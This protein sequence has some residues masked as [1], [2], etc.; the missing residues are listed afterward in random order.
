MHEM[1]CRRGRPHERVTELSKFGRG[2]RSGIRLPPRLAV[3]EGEASQR[4][5]RGDPK[6]SV[7][8]D[9][10]AID[11]RQWWESEG[12]GPAEDT[13]VGVESTDGVTIDKQEQRVVNELNLG[14]HSGV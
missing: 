9:G 10:L 1:G 13:G 6:T 4:I 3:A 2:G 14:W 8:S 7:T 12:G 5:R 11:I